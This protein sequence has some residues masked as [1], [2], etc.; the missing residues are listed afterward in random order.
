M[1]VTKQ[2]ASVPAPDD[3]SGASAK[4]V[5]VERPETALSGE[6]V[7]LEALA[8]R[9]LDRFIQLEPKVLRGEDPEAIHDMR[10][11]SRRLQ[12]ILDL[13]YPP[14]APREVRRL[15]RR[16][17]RCRRALGEVRNCDVLLE[18]VE[19]SLSNKRKKEP[20]AQKPGPHYSAIWEVAR[21]Y[22]GARRSESFHKALGKLGK[23][24]V[25]SLYVGLK[26]HLTV[27]GAGPQGG[28]PGQ[29]E[30]P[31]G[32]NTN[33][34]P[35]MEAQQFYERV[36]GSMETAW[37]DFVEKVAESHRQPQASTLHGVRIAAKRLRYLVEVIE[38]FQVPGSGESA[39]W[40]R[41]LQQHLGDW[42]DLE[43]MEGMLT[44]ML[45]RPKFIRD[46]LEMASDV[47]SLIRRN[48]RRKKAFEESYLQV[49]RHSA[50]YELTKRWATHLI[51]SPAAVFS[52][53]PL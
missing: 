18:R 11:A 41:G 16:I 38:E 52:P 7:K 42:H 50:E 26:E 49:T 33:P 21:D 31:Q 29:V 22:L 17:R 3:G 30:K 4:L 35:H 34:V 20:P 15:R 2:R 43:V 27:N 19:K 44:E 23:V 37:K 48:R 8:L 9:H 47:L 45:A 13:I 28:N 12:Q 39:A 32:H 40:L 14:P 1:P 5:A 6:W 10:V 24:N 46:H 53:P 25:A 51:S 36:G